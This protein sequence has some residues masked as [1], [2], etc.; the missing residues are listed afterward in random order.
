MRGSHALEPLHRPLPSSGRLMRILSSIIAP[1]TAIM[2][3]CDPKMTG[4]SSIRS[5]PRGEVG[6]RSTSQSSRWAHTLLEGVLRLSGLYWRGRRNAAKL[7]LR[8]NEIVSHRIPKAFD[9]F[10][11]LHLSDLH[12]EMSQQAMARLLDLPEPGIRALHPHRRLSGEG[13]WTQNF[14]CVVGEK[15][16]VFAHD[17]L[18]IGEKSNA[19][20]GSAATM[21]HSPHSLN[22][23]NAGEHPNI[24]IMWADLVGGQRR[25]KEFSASDVFSSSVIK[26]PIPSLL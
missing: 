14:I 23:Q 6:P 8:R 4:C 25:R 20:T 22:D 10:R 2:A 13:F 12:T 1:S 11:I 19:A 26:S 21:R 18:A 7:L 9:G 5:Q 24:G 15:G 3:F 16:K 17:F